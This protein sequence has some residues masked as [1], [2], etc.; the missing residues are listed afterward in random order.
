M[1]TRDD[2]N[3]YLTEQFGC[4]SAG[5]SVDKTFYIQGKCNNPRLTIEIYET[6]YSETNEY[7]FVYVDQQPIANCTDLNQRCTGD[8]YV[9]IHAIIYYIFLL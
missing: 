3:A 7:A 9:T 1:C 4:T 8:W 6:D 5:C 2:S